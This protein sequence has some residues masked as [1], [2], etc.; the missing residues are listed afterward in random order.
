MIYII[1]DL[2]QY[3]PILKQ[4]NQ[5]T[6][7]ALQRVKGALSRLRDALR[8]DP[9]K[10]IPT[11][12]EYLAARAY[13]HL[14]AATKHMRYEQRQETRERVARGLIRMVSEEEGDYKGAVEMW[15]LFRKRLPNQ[16]TDKDYP[17]EP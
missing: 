4:S 3:V 17:S 16:I 15:K 5:T 6:A 10:D 11:E 9:F 12:E 14:I 13:G 8:W 1:R 7:P 2:I